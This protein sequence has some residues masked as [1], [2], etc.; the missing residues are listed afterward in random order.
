MSKRIALFLATFL[1]CFTWQKIASTSAAFSD[2]PSNHP[3]KS[4]IDFVQSQG[5]VSGYPDGTY[6]PERL[7]NRAEFTKIIVESRF[8]NVEIENCVASEGFYKRAIFSDVE[9]AVWFEKYVCVAKKNKII[10]GYPDGSFKPVQTINFAEAAK[11]VTNSYGLSVGTGDPWFA[12]FVGKL[13]ALNAVPATIAI[14]RSV[15]DQGLKLVSRGEM[16]EVIYRLRTI[17]DTVTSS[18]GS[19][20][21]KIPEKALPS[22]LS[23]SAISIVK[24]PVGEG[25]VRE[26]NGAPMVF[27]R[28]EP[29]GVQFRQPVTFEIKT[30]TL[31]NTIPMVFLVS[32]N[33]FDMIPDPLIEIDQS[34]Q[35]ALLSGQL[36]HFSHLGLAYVNEFAVTLEGIPDQV[37][38]GDQFDFVAQISRLSNNSGFLYQNKLYPIGEGW[39]VSNGIIDTLPPGPLIPSRTT[40]IPASSLF[41]GQ[42]NYSI[43]E[44]YVCIEP[45]DQVRVRYQFGL[46]FIVDVVSYSAFVGIVTNPFSCEGSSLELEPDQDYES[47]YFE[48]VLQQEPPS[49]AESVSYSFPS[50]PISRPRSQPTYTNPNPNNLNCPG[51]QYLAPEQGGVLTDLMVLVPA[52]KCVAMPRE[53]GIYQ[54]PSH[55]GGCPSTHEHANASFQT[56]DGSMLSDPLV[57]ISPPDCGLGRVPS[58]AFISSAYLNPNQLNTPAQSNAFM[59]SSKSVEIDACTH[60]P[61][62]DFSN[63][64]TYLVEGSFISIMGSTTSGGSF[65]LTGTNN[66]SFSVSGTSTVASVNNVQI[67]LQG[68]LPTSGTTNATLTIGAN[69]VLPGGCPI[70]YSL[71]LQSQ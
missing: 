31:K 69:G 15:T 44:Q 20:S 32:G 43:L 53:K 47:F 21:I 41:S 26:V 11:I 8:T 10:D 54:S 4:A 45:N 36:A 49:S 61:L 33:S 1:L 14:H 66:G 27:Y 18:D 55:P 57:Q 19:F 52:G 30:P 34:S 50:M 16:A 35:T 62:M 9:P 51:A 71:Q 6:Q 2:V 12:P 24:V 40:N 64:F 56:L 58:E 37:I 39:G 42:Q 3:N 23:L 46:N 7:L 22:G 28:L 67:D 48:E 25:P 65:T 29:D 63:N 60:H 17:Q 13:N 5:I 38:N 59:I 70:I 68:T